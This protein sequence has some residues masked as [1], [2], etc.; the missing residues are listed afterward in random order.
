MPFVSTEE[1]SEMSKAN[2]EMSSDLNRVS[3]TGVL[4]SALALILFLGV[5]TVNMK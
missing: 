4:S 1:V 5:E 3:T 2:H